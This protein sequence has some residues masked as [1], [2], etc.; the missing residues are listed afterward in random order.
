LI[1]STKHNLKYQTKLKSN[2]LNDS[3]EMLKNQISYYIDLMCSGQLPIEKF[4]TS[5]DLPDK[6]IAHSQWKTICYK[7]ASEI[8][9]SQ[10]KRASN[11]RYKE[12]KKLYAKSFDKNGK[13]KHPS[14]TNKK[15]KELK[16]KS[17]YISKYFKKPN[18]S[19]FSLNV[20]SRLFDIRETN[21]HFNGF[22]HL[23]LPMFIVKK[24]RPLAVSI[25]IPFNYTRLNN[26][27]YNNYNN[28]KLTNTIRLNIKN[29]SIFL[30]LIYEKDEPN[31][32]QSGTIIGLDSG[33][34]KLGSLSNG[35]FIGT[36][37]ETIINK[38]VHK[39]RGS[40]S[41]KKSLIERT[42]YINRELKKIDFSSI[43]E[44]V[45]EDLKNVKQNSKL[46]HKMNNRL[47]YW[48]YSYMISKLEMLCS[49]NGVL[50]TKANPAY[51]SQTCSKCGS[52]HKE[53][54]KGE[55][56]HCTEC[57]FETDA[58]Y[59]ASVNLSHMGIYGSHDQEPNFIDFH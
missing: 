50:L 17:I 31:K 6:Y 7:S 21:N 33:Y 53:S 9:R 25:N 27:K 16:L 5:K 52:V 36:E 28:W 29:N 23:R 14:F 37:L 38:I 32:K 1:R 34:K 26:I 12:Y 15:F 8:I 41:Y 57:G 10:Y 49:E 55:L 44:L 59:N 4:L 20:D 56:F 51:T 47:S 24:V 22:L 40:K 42:E 54:R 11:K 2:L 43:K 13:S 58:D 35:T 18:L 45:I 30:E 39:V 19:N 48:I 3:M 46:N